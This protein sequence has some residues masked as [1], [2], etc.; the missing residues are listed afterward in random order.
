MY[1]EYT[2]VKDAMIKKQIIITGDLDLQNTVTH[3]IYMR[4]YTDTKQVKTHNIVLI[5]GEYYVESRWLGTENEV[6]QALVDDVNK[7][8]MYQQMTYEDT[9]SFEEF[10]SLLSRINSC[11]LHISH[12]LLADYINSITDVQDKEAMWAKYN[13]LLNNRLLHWRNI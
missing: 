2:K 6:C 12:Y 13:W 5:E 1:I 7:V 11:K 4:Y 8:M 3:E 10:K 9:L